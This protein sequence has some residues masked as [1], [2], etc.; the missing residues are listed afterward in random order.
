MVH[1]TS[2]IR[3]QWSKG[4]IVG[5]LFADVKSAFPSVHHPRLL[6]TLREKGTNNQVL[7]LIHEFLTGR[8][9]V[10]SFN[11]FTSE[12]FDLTHGLPQGSPLSPLLYLI[13]NSSLLDIA[14][15]LDHAEALGFINDVVLLSSANDTHQLT[16]QMQTL[17][18]RQSMWAKK[19]GAIFDTKKS[20]WVVYSPKDIPITRTIDFGDRLKLKPEKSSKWLGVTFDSQLSFKQH[21]QDFITKGSQRAGFLATLSNTQWGIAPKLM[22]TLLTTT[23]HTAT[24]YGAAAWLPMEVPEYFTVM[25]WD[26]Y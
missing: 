5:A 12:P 10:L 11:S 17:S 2:W 3:R 8:S 25:A 15:N 26:V 6:N 13:Y 22:R 16:S 23:V 14:N 7:N 9:T 19:H 21:R 24:D 20:Y 1:L 18:Y 4:K